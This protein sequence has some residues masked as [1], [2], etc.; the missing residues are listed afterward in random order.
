MQILK[1]ETDVAKAF[2]VPSVLEDLVDLECEVGVMVARNKKGEIQV[3]PPVTM[4][5]DP[6]LNLV[7]YVVSPGEIT[8]NL[9][10]KCVQLAKS[11]AE[12]F[13]LVGIMAVELFITKEGGVLVNECAPGCITLVI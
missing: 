5:F 10:K 9:N 4:D 3:F 13:E 7:K 1:S 6:D 2:D 8:D 12:K 11:T